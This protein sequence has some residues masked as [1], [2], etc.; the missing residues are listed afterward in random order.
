MKQFIEKYIGNRADWALLCI[1][2][3]VGV[4]FV[5][6]GIQKLNMGMEGVGNFFGAVGIPFAAMFAWIVT[7]LEIMGG[8]ALIVGFE[9]RFGALLLSIVM[10]VAIIAVKLK[11]GLVGKGGSGFE[12]ELTLLAANLSLFFQG[13]GRF[14]WDQKRSQNIVPPIPKVL[15]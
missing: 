7:A 3:A 13:A 4:I 14:S 1:R 12:L 15:S 5:A 6:H 11:G 10:A 2:L 8:L 9:V